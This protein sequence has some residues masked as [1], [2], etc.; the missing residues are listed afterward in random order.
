MHGDSRTEPVSNMG[1]GHW[2]LQCLQRRWCSTSQ[3]AVFLRN[4]LGIPERRPR[5]GRTF[6]QCAPS[7][8]HSRLARTPGRMEF[9]L[10]GIH[11]ACAHSLCASPSGVVDLRSVGGHG[12]ERKTRGGRWDR[13][14]ASDRGNQSGR[15]GG[16]DNEPPLLPAHAPGTGHSRGLY[17]LYGISSSPG[18]ARRGRFEPRRTH[19]QFL[20]PTR[21]AGLREG[22]DGPGSRRCSGWIARAHGLFGK[23]TLLEHSHDPPRPLQCWSTGRSV[24]A[25]DGR[26]GIFVGN[27]QL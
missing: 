9:D 12:I 13:I 2:A 8:Q 10:Y 18:A 6:L 11:D 5:Y 1:L 23:P 7:R 3:S 16:R 4:R 25:P 22:I 27:Q 14:A 17:W 15:T 19:V 20:W 21:L 24:R 26:P